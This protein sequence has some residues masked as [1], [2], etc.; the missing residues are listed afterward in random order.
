M[1]FVEKAPIRMSHWIEHN[2]DHSKEYESLA[3]EL[4]SA[5]KIE[6]AQCIREMTALIFQA[7]DCLV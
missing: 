7:N 4:E 3:R 1:E 6:S 2:E 5:G